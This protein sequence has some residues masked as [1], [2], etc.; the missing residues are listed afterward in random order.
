[1]RWEPSVIL[2]GAYTCIARVDEIHRATGYRGGP[3]R[4]ATFAIRYPEFW[5]V[6]ADA[7][8]LPRGAEAVSRRDPAGVIVAFS[9]KA[10]PGRL[11]FTLAH[12]VGHAFLHDPERV[13]ARRGRGERSAQEGRR[14]AQADFFAAELLM[15]VWA[16]DRALP[17][18]WRRGSTAE[19]ERE[20]G[21]L[22]GL[23][24]VSRAA[25]R[26]QLEHYL[27]VRES[28]LGLEG[29]IVEHLR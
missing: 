4:F 15:P 17:R 12:E 10:S 2:S 29:S 19:F 6:E 23:F 26:V 21:R 3:F 24:W 27:R 14:E 13:H 8:A 11:R 9:P 7:S 5:F 22:A 16:V 18:N 28:A 20:V 1:M 25:M